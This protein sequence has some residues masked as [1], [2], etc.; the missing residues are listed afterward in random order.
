M[1]KSKRHWFLTPFL[2]AYIKYILWRNFGVIKIHKCSEVADTT[3]I[4]IANHISWWDGFWGLYL[5]N[6]ELKRKLY[7]MMLEEQLVKNKILRYGGAFSI[8]R[9]SRGVL[10]SLNYAISLAKENASMILMYPQGKM[11]SIY[12]NEFDFEP[13]IAYLLT[14][15]EA[16]S[17]LF[18]VSLPDFGAGKKPY[19][20]IY[21]KQHLL[22]SYA[23]LAIAEAYKVFYKECV[24]ESIISAK[25]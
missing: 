6:S 19:V 25:E 7:V 16:R 11:K 1:I 24:A 4:A 12:N 8:K 15:S 3:K 20:N 10:E 5:C 9:S 17:A 13:G 14:K 23:T 2:K 22:E 18:V 21:Y